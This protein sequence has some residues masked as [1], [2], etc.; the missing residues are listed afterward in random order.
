LQQAAPPPPLLAPASSKATGGRRCARAASE[1]ERT[2]SAACLQ[3]EGLKEH[4]LAVLFRNNH[5]NA[6]FK[7][8]GALYMLVTDQGYLHEPDV[9][10]ERLDAVDGNTQM[11]GCDFR[12]FRPHAEEVPAELLYDAGGAA[13]GGAAAGATAAGGGGGAPQGMSERR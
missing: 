12:P 4:Q 6:L 1:Q 11:C 2:A 3:V 8:E 13:G 10:W 9:V 5:F 7:Q